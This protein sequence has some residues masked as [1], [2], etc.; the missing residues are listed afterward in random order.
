M[1]E[2]EVGYLFS[3]PVIVWWLRVSTHTGNK[4]TTVLNEWAW[5][6]TFRRLKWS[7]MRFEYFGPCIKR[8]CRS[9]EVGVSALRKFIGGFK[10]IGRVLVSRSKEF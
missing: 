3:L 2:E 1:V 7:R 5:L 10:M 9:V 6:D 8:I 4:I